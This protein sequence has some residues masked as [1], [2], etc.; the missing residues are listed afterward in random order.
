METPAVV[1]HFAEGQINLV[2]QC[3]VAEAF[4]LVARW[5][6]DAEARCEGGQVIGN[7]VLLAPEL[8]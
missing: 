6:N 5:Q 1:H 2:A 8:V 3:V 4:G 7:I